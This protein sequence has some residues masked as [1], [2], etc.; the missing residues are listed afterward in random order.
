MQVT[1][2]VVIAALGPFV[3]L[4]KGKKQRFLSRLLVNDV[5]CLNI[6]PHQLVAPPGQPFVLGHEVVVVGATI[7][8]VFECKELVLSYHGKR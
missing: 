8:K 5:T 1:Y 6:S 7:V 3:N 4:I 2:I